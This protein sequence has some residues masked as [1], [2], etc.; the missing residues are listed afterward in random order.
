MINDQDLTILSVNFKGK[1][2]LDLNYAC[3]TALNNTDLLNWV[4][5]ENT[6]DDADGRLNLEDGR[7]QVVKG[8]EP[9]RMSTKGR[10]SYHHGAALNKGKEYMKTRFALIL[11]PDFF[12]VRKDW[13]AGI[14]NYMVKNQLSFFGVP[15]H[16]RYYQKYRYFPCVH[17]LFIDLSRVSLEE[18]DFRPDLVNSPARQFKPGFWIGYQHLRSQGK[19]MQAWFRLLRQPCRA[20]REDMRQRSLIGSTRDTGELIYQRYGLDSRVFETVQPVFRPGKDKFLPAG[21][22]GLQYSR[23]VELL[24]PDKKR[25][26]P[27]QKNYFTGTGFHELGYADVSSLGWEEFI[28]QRRPYGFHV[29]GS[30]QP[31]QDSEKARTALVEVLRNLTGIEL[32]GRYHHLSAR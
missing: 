17:N 27:K 8:V 7:F 21:V 3:A 6:P 24:L 32:P 4:T 9:P 10:A 13:I 25:Y 11:D 28:W 20:A 30:L 16:P 5:V 1:A 2:F 22:S 23:V 19:K 29:R 18:L 15:W 26:I 12:I 31:A 14:L